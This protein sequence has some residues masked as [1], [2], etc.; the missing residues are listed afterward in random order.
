MTNAASCASV[1]EKA[2]KINWA[3]L[4]WSSR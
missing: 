4:D 1:T 3:H 2:R